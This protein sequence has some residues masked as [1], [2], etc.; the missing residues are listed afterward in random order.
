MKSPNSHIVIWSFIFLIIFAGYQYYQHIYTPV[1]LPGLPELKPNERCP[2]FVLP[3][4]TG[5]NRSLAEWD[6]KIVVI[7]FWATWCR[8]CLKEIP[9]LIKLQNEY[10][11][12]NIHFIG[13]AVRDELKSVKE[14]ATHLGINYPVL[15]DKQGLALSKAFGNTIDAL[16]FTVV[17]DRQGYIVSR[18]AGELNERAAKK[19]IGGQRVA[20]PTTDN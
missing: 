14:V 4:I 7:N 18:F 9:I 20:H 11:K 13:I 2:D 10:A 15:F 8:S 17:V 19:L 16:P 3:D 6:G 12:E 1:S 5:K